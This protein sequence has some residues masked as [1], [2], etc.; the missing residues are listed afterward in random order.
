MGRKYV[1]DS[2]CV[3]LAAVHT[4]M[5]NAIEDFQKRRDA[6]DPLIRGKERLVLFMHGGD[7][8]CRL[9]QYVSMYKLSFFR[10]FSRYSSGSSDF[11]QGGTPLKI[12]EN[13]SSSLLGKEDLSASLPD[14]AGVLAYHSIIVQGVFHLMYLKAAGNCADADEF[15]QMRK[16]YIAM[17]KE[18]FHVLEFEAPPGRAAIFI[19]GLI[20]RIFPPLHGIAKYFGHGIYNNNGLRKVLS[21]F[22]KKW[23]TPVKADKEKIKLR[24]HVDGEL[25]MRVAQLNEILK[26]VIDSIG[27]GSFELVYSPIWVF[28]ENILEA[29]ILVAEREI[30]HL[31]NDIMNL[32]DKKEKKN[33][34]RLIKERKKIIKETESDIG[35]F[36]NILAGPLYRAGGLNMPHPMKKV[37]AAA[38]PVI[39]TYK[40]FGELVPYTGETVLNLRDG[41]DLIFNVA[42]EGCMVSSMGQTLTPKILREGGNASAIV[43]N[44][45]SSE[46]ELDDE[47]IQLAILK[48]LG[49]V[50]Y[51]SS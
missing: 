3:P 49:P 40:P 2:V 1:G 25:Y 22:S 5:L 44:L 21:K 36:R 7:G 18:I 48:I 35:N 17:K 41:I 30:Q 24:M 23:I 28:F 26:S 32:S 19:V 9:G 29:R 13:L 50:K 10:M 37:F 51:Y 42:P 20:G 12:I 15:E 8:P 33:K 38:K 43:Q 11:G 39:P 45:S 47:I 4:D 27:Y 34:L 46:G 31:Q 16:D 6:D 14:W